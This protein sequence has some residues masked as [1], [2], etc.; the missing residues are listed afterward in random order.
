MIQV[1]TVNGTVFKHYEGDWLKRD[2]RWVII[3]CKD[4]SVAAM[5]PESQVMQ[6]LLHEAGKAEEKTMSENPN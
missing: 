5:Y 6:V 4:S 2:N 1:T 3:F